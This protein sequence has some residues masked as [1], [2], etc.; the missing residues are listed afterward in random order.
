MENRQLR[1]KRYDGATFVLT[2]DAR[3]SDFTEERR[4]AIHHQT[5]SRDSTLRSKH[6][7]HHR[8]HTHSAVALKARRKHKSTVVRPYK[9]TRT[10]A[11]GTVGRDLS[12][13]LGVPILQRERSIQVSHTE[14]KATQRAK[15]TLWASS[16][17]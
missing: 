17:P 14:E 4:D 13:I 5:Q 1:S 12:I 10:Y 3:I 7:A 6:S 2:K 9:P 15:T 11:K 16:S 8:P